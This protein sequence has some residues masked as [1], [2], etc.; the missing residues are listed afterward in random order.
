MFFGMSAT[1]N[2]SGGTGLYTNSDLTKLVAN[3]ASRSVALNGSN[4]FIYFAYPSSFGDLSTILDGNG[5]NVT[6]SFTKN[7]S[8]VTSTGKALDWTEEYNI[9]KT[10]SVTSV[11]GQTFQFNF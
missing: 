10:N 1:D 5:F 11:S 9:Y 7:V 6:S 3:T 8:N 4:E 2:S